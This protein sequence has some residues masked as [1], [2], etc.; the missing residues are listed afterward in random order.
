MST[1]ILATRPV[2]GGEVAGFL[3]VWEAL[4]FWGLWALAL[5]FSVDWASLLNYSRKLRVE[6]SP[7]DICRREDPCCGCHLRM[8]TR[9]GT[10]ACVRTLT[11]RESAVSTLKAGIATRECARISS[12]IRPTPQ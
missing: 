2:R 10:L 4:V 12:I 1:R 3:R 11:A 9:E 5:L 7:L 6:F 8:Q